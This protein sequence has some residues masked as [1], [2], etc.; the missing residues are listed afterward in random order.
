M[1]AGGT[2]LLKFFIVSFWFLAVL[3]KFNPAIGL[4]WAQ[5]FII[6]FYFLVPFFINI[7]QELPNSTRWPICT[8]LTTFY[9]AVFALKS[10]KR[11]IHKRHFFYKI[12]GKCRA[13]FTKKH[14]F[15]A[16]SVDRVLF[17]HFKLKLHWSMMTTSC[18]FVCN[19]S[20][21]QKY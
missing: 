13:V 6:F 9:T 7:Y 14:N 11:V 5:K 1:V 8:I 18:T 4:T 12:D 15:D 17:G 20:F 2:V 10:P 19:V 21:L 16:V 3:G